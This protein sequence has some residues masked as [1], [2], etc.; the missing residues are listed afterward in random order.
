MRFKGRN[1]LVVLDQLRAVDK[2]RLVR[3]MGRVD[4]KSLLAALAMLRWIFS[5]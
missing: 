2:S 4:E 5:E 3:R 1:G